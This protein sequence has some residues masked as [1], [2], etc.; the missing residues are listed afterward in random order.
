MSSLV[1]E[2]EGPRVREEG[3]AEFRTDKG[4]AGQLRCEKRHGCCCG[5][6]GLEITAGRYEVG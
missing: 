6:R 5:R 2:Y 1:Y 3:G 4:A